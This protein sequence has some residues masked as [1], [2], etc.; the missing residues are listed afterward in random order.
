MRRTVGIAFAVVTTLWLLAAGAQAQ[1]V[2]LV[3]LPEG[4]S[5][6]LVVDQ[7]GRAREMRPG[8]PV[9]LRVA[10]NVVIGNQLVIRAGTPVTGVTRRDYFRN[11]YVD[12]V[13]LRPLTAMGG[14]RIPLEPL[15]VREV[16]VLGRP[17]RYRGGSEVTATVAREIVIPLRAERRRERA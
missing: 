5:I 3:I 13:V 1:P 11:G 12:S 2:R 9:R 16:F 15:G 7:Y 10:D 4:T 14:V 17:L 8:L 6:G